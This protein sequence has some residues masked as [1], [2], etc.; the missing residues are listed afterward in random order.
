[1]S[2][3]ASRSLRQASRLCLKQSMSPAAARVRSSAVARVASTS[4]PGVSR[5]GYVSETKKDS[6]QVNLDSAIRSEQK[7][8][9]EETGKHAENQ[10]IP[11]SSVNADAMMSPMA[12]S[13]S[14]YVYVDK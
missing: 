12:G 3:V 14:S 9:F 11:G 2:S 10:S 1:M 13:Y 4:Y 8:F 6:A 7:S 5:R